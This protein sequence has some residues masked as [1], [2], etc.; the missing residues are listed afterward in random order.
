M[1]SV[2]ERASSHM[3]AFDK[4]YPFH[5]SATMIVGKKQI[6]SNIT[7]WIIRSSKVMKMQTVRL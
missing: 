7:S 6:C 3:F 4:G 2:E 5:K 1:Q